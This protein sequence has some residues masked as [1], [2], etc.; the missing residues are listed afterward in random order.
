[1][2]NQNVTSANDLK[3]NLAMR[4]FFSPGL[5]VHGFL[6]ILNL[7]GVSLKMNHYRRKMA[8]N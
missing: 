6:G 7:L 4:V 3:F 5:S 8:K 2:Q 1:M